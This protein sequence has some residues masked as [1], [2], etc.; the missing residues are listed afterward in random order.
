[1]KTSLLKLQSGR[2]ELT[3]GYTIE[4]FTVYKFYFISLKIKVALLRL[5]YSWTRR[6]WDSRICM[7]VCC[8]DMKKELG[9]ELPDKGVRLKENV[10]YQK[11]IPLIRSPL[12]WQDENWGKG[13]ECDMENEWGN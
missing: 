7:G 2:E 3:P 8:I 1:M 9:T 11:Y 6:L 4:I 10:I 12:K 13:F 5:V